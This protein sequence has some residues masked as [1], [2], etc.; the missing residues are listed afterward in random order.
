[1]EA[2]TPDVTGEGEGEQAGREKGESGGKNLVLSPID[3]GF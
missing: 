2:L 1:M 3:H